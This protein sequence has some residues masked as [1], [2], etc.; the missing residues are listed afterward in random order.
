MAN[1][2]PPMAWRYCGNQIKRWRERAGVTREALAEEASC[3][4]EYV[5]SMETG[6][7]KP[8]L[9]LLQVADGLCGAGGLL[10]AAREYLVPEKFPSYSQDYMRYEAEAPIISWYEP[11]LMPGLLQT[12][13]TARAL[14]N[15]HLPPLD[16]ETIDV[17]VRARLERQHLLDKQTKSFNFVLS[18][19]ILRYPVGTEAE[20]ARQLTRLLELGE[21]RNVAIQVLPFKGAH[22]GL[23]GPFVLLETPDHGRLAYEEGQTTG[24]LYSDPEKIRVVTQRH[25][26]ILRQ[27]LSMEESARF[28]R[29]L[30]EAL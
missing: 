16:D 27:A 18:E 28:M 12:E 19:V 26:M 4:Y 10:I 22:P 9:H 14:F 11:L 30:T 25:A 21:R 13:E 17:R 23:L 15:E 8:T 29:K 3:S 20:H 7:R 6:R 2:E 5:K 1:P 24:V